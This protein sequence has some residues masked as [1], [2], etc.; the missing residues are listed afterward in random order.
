[1]DPIIIILL[2][3]FGIISLLLTGLILIQEDQGDGMGG[4]FGGGSNNQV[5]NRKGNFLTKAT[6]VLGIAF[7]V[8]CVL[9][10]VKY[11]LDDSIPNAEVLADIEI[12]KPVLSP[13][14]NNPTPTPL[15]ETP[16][17]DPNAPV[18]DGTLPVDG[19]NDAAN[20]NTETPSNP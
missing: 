11:R 9:F 3:L 19:V 10:A 20:G 14:Y 1:M 12:S 5:G 13:W 17:V 8:I 18:P 15:N 6:S 2:V 4:L 7:L 16:V